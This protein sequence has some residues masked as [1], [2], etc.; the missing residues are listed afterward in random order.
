MWTIGWLLSNCIIESQ[1]L[2]VDVVLEQNS[3]S[4]KLHPPQSILAS[5]FHFHV[6][7]FLRF[8]SLG[9]NPWGAA[10][11]QVS[12]FI[13]V[14]D[15]CPYDDGNQ[16]NQAEQMLLYFFRA[17]SQPAVA[18]DRLKNSYRLGAVWS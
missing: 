14:V 8:K 7:S 15:S 11:P 16:V 2:S 10:L 9:T 1:P 5:V 6:F 4:V 12:F 18:L 13:V 3:S 17:N